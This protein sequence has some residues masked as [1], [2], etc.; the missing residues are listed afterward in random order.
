MSHYFLKITSDGHCS[1]RSAGACL[2]FYQG[3]NQTNNKQLSAIQFL[4]SIGYEDEQLFKGSQKSKLAK[5]LN[6]KRKFYTNEVNTAANPDS[7]M[8]W[9]IAKALKLV[10]NTPVALNRNQYTL[11][12][13]GSVTVDNI[14]KNKVLFLHSG[15]TKSGHWNI[16]LPKTQEYLNRK[17]ALE[18]SKASI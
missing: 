1:P 18:L 16:A 10:K 5:L 12:R 11:H 7:L 3:K 13:D 15:S 6:N 4:H 9:R 14:Y 17:L 2:L 8:N